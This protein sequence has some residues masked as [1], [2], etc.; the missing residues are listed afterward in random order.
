MRE[1]ESGEITRKE[2]MLLWMFDG[3]FDG[4]SQCSAEL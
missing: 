2:A 1:R 3:G 4:R